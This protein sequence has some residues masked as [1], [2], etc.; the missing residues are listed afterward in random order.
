MKLTEN[1]TSMRMKKSMRCMNK[2]TI[3]ES[4][5]QKDIHDTGA[6]HEI[7][8]HEEMHETCLF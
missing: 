7:H 6:I 8:K 5:E 1:V 4:H 3:H 2:Y